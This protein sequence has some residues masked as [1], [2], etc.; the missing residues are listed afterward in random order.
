LLHV[1]DSHYGVTDA[2]A[3]FM[4]LLAFWATVSLPLDGSHWWNVAL[5]GSLC[6]LAAA[7]K[8]NALLIA[9]PLLVRAAQ[10]TAGPGRPRA[11]SIAGIVLV[12][13]AF[14]VIGFAV[15]TPY[16][17]L[18]RRTFVR[19]FLAERVHL[20]GGHGLDE[21]LGWT[22]HLTFSLR[23][24][25]TVPLLL[26]AVAG[27]VLLPLAGPQTAWVVLAFPLCYYTAMGSGRTTFVRYMTPLVP[28]AALLS[29][30]AIDSAA[31][32]A[33]RAAARPALRAWV[34]VGLTLMVGFE[35]ARRSVALDRLLAVPDS[36]VLAAAWVRNRYPDGVSVYQSGAGYAH[37]QLDPEGAYPDAVF[38]DARGTFV[39]LGTPSSGP[40]LVIVP[41]SRLKNYTAMPSSLPSVIAS[42]YRLVQTID[43]E[44]PAS[45]A[46]PVF[47]QLDAFFVPLTGFDRFTRP[48][49]SIEIYELRR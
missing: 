17:I 42:D 15:G 35:S 34:L 32:A 10:G 48:G 22:Q 14:A 23:Y 1:R 46:R 29:G 43:V 36:R 24:G 41:V 47:D 40:R 2:P 28:F 33:A 12:I 30:V 49:P 6:G 5:A 38:D 25:L 3:T 26:A 13:V 7:T 37:A 39:F 9:A 16:A 31:R 27:G 8:Y 18:D 11:A 44:N 20:A 45:A 21:G 4:I 19:D